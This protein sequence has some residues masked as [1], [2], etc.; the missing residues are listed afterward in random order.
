[1]NDPCIAIWFGNFFELFLSNREATRRGIAD[2][3]ELGFTTISLDSKPWEDFFA[4]YRGEPSLQSA[5]HPRH[6]SEN[7]NP[8]SAIRI[9]LA[10]GARGDLFGHLA[11]PSWSARIA[12]RRAS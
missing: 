6:Q 8:P 11:L 7:G 4:R 5:G 1:M 9:R 3:A 10:G 12:G 2:V